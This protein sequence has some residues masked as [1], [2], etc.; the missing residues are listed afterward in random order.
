MVSEEE[1][2]NFRGWLIVIGIAV[3]FLAW[4]LF[5]YF[6]V[7]DKGQGPWDF[8]TVAD[9]PG[10]S[11]YSTTPPGAGSAPPHEQHI[12]EETPG[13]KFIKENR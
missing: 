8:G 1:K 11:P 13:A 4:A 12:S 10:E 7:G 9:I 6:L 5:A 2:G 3:F